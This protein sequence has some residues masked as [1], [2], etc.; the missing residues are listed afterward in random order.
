MP[1]APLL[2][3]SPAGSDRPSQDNSMRTVQSSTI[4]H[5]SRTKTISLF[6]VIRVTKTSVS[7]RQVFL[8]DCLRHALQYIQCRE[9][10]QNSYK[11][12]PNWAGRYIRVLHR[13]AIF[14]VQA[15]TVARRMTMNEDL[16]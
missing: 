1:S 14:I 12:L 13:P 5:R 10:R 16:R 9:Y 2:T 15:A 11:T 4:V 3:H 6:E 8:C 7:T